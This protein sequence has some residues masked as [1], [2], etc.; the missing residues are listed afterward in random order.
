MDWHTRSFHFEAPQYKALE[1]ETFVRSMK[2]LEHKEN[3]DGTKRPKCPKHL[4]VGANAF[5]KVATRKDT[6]LIYVF[7]SPNVEPHPHE[8]A[9]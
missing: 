8:I 5:M 3:L 6:F 7:P 2:N 1:C 9:S 4:F